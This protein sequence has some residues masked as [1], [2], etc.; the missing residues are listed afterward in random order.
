MQCISSK[1]SKITYIIASVHT[2][3][4]DRPL[5][6]LSGNG[7]GILTVIIDQVVTCLDYHDLYKDYYCNI[8]IRTMYNIY[9]IFYLI[10]VHKPEVSNT[11]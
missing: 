8:L 3:C 1:L 10:A 2:T 9:E 7:S 4:G 5:S 11:V 6:R